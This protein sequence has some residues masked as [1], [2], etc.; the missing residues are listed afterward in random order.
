MIESQEGGVPLDEILIRAAGEVAPHP[1]AG[2]L[3]E[4][5]KAAGNQEVFTREAAGFDS[6]QPVGYGGIQAGVVELF[7]LTR[8]QR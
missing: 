5:F 4:E 7:V 8:L 6:L 3:F 2:E 1:T